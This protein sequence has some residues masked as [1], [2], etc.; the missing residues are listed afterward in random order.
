[1]EASLR[2][3]F[4]SK[5]YVVWLLT[6]E[7]ILVATPIVPAKKELMCML[8]AHIFFIPTIREFGILSTLLFPLIDL[9]I[10]H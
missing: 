2:M 9:P 4:I 3:P 1:M 7:G 8:T 6:S 5:G 10:R